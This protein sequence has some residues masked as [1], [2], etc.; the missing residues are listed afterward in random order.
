MDMQTDAADARPPSSDA[1]SLGADSRQ[2][3][4]FLIDDGIFA[5]PLAEVQEIIRMPAIVQVPLSHASLE[6]LANLRGTVM[7]I[8]SLRRIFRYP[9]LAHD[10]ATRVVVINQGI[11]VGLVVDRMS[12]VVTA[13]PD[14]IENV[15]SIEGTINTDLLRGMIKATDGRGMIMILDPVRLVD[16]EFGSGGRRA[17]RVR[18]SA[19]EVEAERAAEAT[20][21]LQLVSFEVAGQEYVLAIEN[22]QEIVQVPERIN[23]VPKTDPH[24]LGVMT[25][26]N[27]LLPL[28]SLRE[29]FGLG[30]VPLDERNKIVVVPLP[31]HTS[32]G[33]VMDQ[34]KEVL[35]V[36]RNLLDPVPPLM[37][38]GSGSGDIQG[39]CRMNGGKR[40]VSV[41]SAEALFENEAV[42]RAAAAAEAGNQEEGAMTQEHARGAGTLEE[43]EQFVVFRLADEEYGVPIGSVQEIVRVPEHLTRLPKAPAFIKGVVNL[44]GSVLPVVDQRTRFDLDDIERNDRQRIMVFTIDGI[45]TGFIVDSVS[46]VLKIPRSA[47]GPMPTLSDKQTDLISRVANLEK[48]KRM[49]MLIDVD[50]LL[51]HHEIGALADASSAAAA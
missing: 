34:V 4:T 5:V 33:I 8:T 30:A 20:D 43:E 28:V 29:M 1:V 3:V 21:E 22:V 18:T 16:S 38:D 17:E 24:V 7:S 45:R 19:A 44:R 41:L 48:Q 32:V 35:R 26:R 6:G 12:A 46:E 39:I 40:L 49:I 13:E 31:D 15:S 23:R 2:Y 36:N 50:H 9:D 11:P 51:E 37:R 27:R 42:R 14:Q 47:I 10:D 25:L